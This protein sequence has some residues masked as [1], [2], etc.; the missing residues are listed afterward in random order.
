MNSVVMLQ[1][2]AIIIMLLGVRSLKIP[3]FLA[4]HICQLINEG[5][6]NQNL[7]NVC[8]FFKVYGYFFSKLLEAYVEVANVVYLPLV[9]LLALANRHE[10]KDIPRRGVGCFLHSS[11]TLHSVKGLHNLFFKDYQ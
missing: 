5:K 9:V 3:W 2:L 4:N 1:F 6:L 7:L 10:K 11:D 8:L